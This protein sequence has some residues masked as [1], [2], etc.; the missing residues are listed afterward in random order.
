MARLKIDRA[1]R[2]VIPKPVREQ[3]GLEAGAELEMEQSGDRIALIPVRSTGPLTKE[4]GV[5]VW[6]TGVRLTAAETEDVLER[7]RM[8]RSES[9][10]GRKR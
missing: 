4:H 8:E 7:V 10:R 1:G 6:R 2:L 9:A 5:W 3:L